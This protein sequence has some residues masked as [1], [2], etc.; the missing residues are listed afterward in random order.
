MCFYSL[1]PN[2]SA[3][4]ITNELLNALNLNI[5][6][7]L[8]SI[9]LLTIS[10][11]LD[12]FL[13]LKNNNRKLKLYRN[14]LK[15]KVDLLN[16]D[17]IGFNEENL[18]NA[19]LVDIYH[20]D[21]FRVFN[22]CVLVDNKLY[23]LNQKNYLSLNKTK[24]SLLNDDEVNT[25]MESNKN[26]VTDE[27][28]VNNKR[29]K[30]KDKKA[31]K[32]VLL[33]TKLTIM[34]AIIVIGPK[35]KTNIENIFI[36]NTREE[37][38]LSY[39]ED[40]DNLTKKEVN[41]LLRY[42]EKEISKVTDDSK[43]YVMNLDSNEEIKNY[44][45]LNAIVDNNNINNSEKE[46][47]Y[48]FIEFFNDI[49]SLDKEKTYNNLANL[50][51]KRF[52]N[53]FSKGIKNDDDN[54]YTVAYY[55]NNNTITY[56]SIPDNLTIGHEVTHAIFDSK[57]IPKAYIEGMAELVQN[58][59][60][61]KGEADYDAYDKNVTLAKATI[62]FIGQDKFIEA[63]NKDDLSIIRDSLIE[64]YLTN[65]VDA[66]FE[67]A[68][69]YSNELI[70]HASNKITNNTNTTDIANILV[71]FF[72]Y[73]D[74]DTEKKIRLFEYREDLSTYYL[75]TNDN[76]Y[77]YFNSEREKELIKTLNN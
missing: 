19:T 10:Y 45:L 76:G 11:F 40:E 20:N 53:P 65:N 2:V 28:I 8:F 39:L 7:S 61:N 9:P 36:D 6:Y 31:F 52:Y 77:Y 22:I 73:A 25:F 13:Q 37:K 54:T 49:P 27:K 56:C 43:Y 64:T 4:L 66:T 30:M 71:N 60:F 3:F 42:I 21:S 15:G 69:M 32:R 14:R 62:E 74:Y 38:I 63:F 5:F 72:R 67:E 50:D 57:N 1:L 44:L 68:T 47:M 24:V 16:K 48:N 29:N 70:K 17:N 33:Y 34:Y 23:I 75:D 18:T 41:E 58:E 12:I 26:G 46:V 59:Y 51:I 35:V 55:S